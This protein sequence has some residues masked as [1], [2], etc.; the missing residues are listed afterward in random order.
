MYSEH[1]TKFGCNVEFTT[2]NYNITTTASKEWM[3]AVGEKSGSRYVQRECPDH[4]MFNRKGERVR[5]LDS[6][7]M[8]IDM[9]QRGE[10]FEPSNDLEKRLFSAIQA[11]K[12]RKEE[13][14][15][16]ILYTG[17]NFLLFNSI[18]R[19]SPD[20]LY[21][22]FSNGHTCPSCK[23]PCNIMKN[24]FDPQSPKHVCWECGQHRSFP[25]NDRSEGI[26]CESSACLNQYMLCPRCV[27]ELKPTDSGNLFTTTIFA[28]VSAIQKLSR[29]MVVP[30]GTLLYRGMGGT[31]D[32][33]DCFYA[34]DQHGCSGYCELAF[35]STSGSRTES[36]TYSGLAS[37][38]PKAVIMV[39]HPSSVDRGAYISDFSQ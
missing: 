22:L 21:K 13:I 4:Q 15:A 20:A 25:W 12:L 30:P 36:I 5:T 38:K 23:K 9:L 31:L 6:V 2:G 11:A 24:F 26:H 1:C 37:G 33:P 17:P 3:Y 16:V 18:L 14:F 28:L 39:I 29:T 8:Y 10:S 34:T 32:M 27:Y 7:Q 35:M 19:R